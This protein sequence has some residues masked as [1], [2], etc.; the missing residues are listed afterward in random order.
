M[1]ESRLA[2][3][4]GGLPEKVVL[5]VLDALEAA[6]FHASANHDDYGA[7]RSVARSACTLEEPPG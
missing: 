4:L 6:E 2:I 1:N 3:M 5:A 7:A